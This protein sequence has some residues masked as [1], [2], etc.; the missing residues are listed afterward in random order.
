MNRDPDRPMSGWNKQ[1]VIA[2][3]RQLVNS[4]ATDIASV[5]MVIDFQLPIKIQFFVDELQELVKS[6][7][8]HE[9]SR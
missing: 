1:S 5:Q 3:A 9:T 4:I 7:G 8:L 2:V 6:T